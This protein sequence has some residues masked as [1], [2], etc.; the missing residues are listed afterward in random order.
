MFAELAIAK[1]R[2]RDDLN[3]D[4]AQAWYVAALS[5]TKT[6]PKLKTLLAKGQKPQRQTPAQMRS[7]LEMLGYKSVPLSD[8]AKKATR[9]RFH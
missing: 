4:L 5:R 2:V 9:L 8:A 6:L 3:R 1:V 7:V